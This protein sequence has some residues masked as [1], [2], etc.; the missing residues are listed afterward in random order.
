LHL[1]AS[2]VLE[3]FINLAVNHLSFYIKLICQR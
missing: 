1:I 2:H 3:D